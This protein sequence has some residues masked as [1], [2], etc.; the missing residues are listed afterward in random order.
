[1]RYSCRFRRNNVQYEVDIFPLT[2]PLHQKDHSKGLSSTTA[3]RKV[4]ARV[5]VFATRSH[6]KLTNI[7]TWHWRLDHVGY[8][9]IKCMGHEQVVK[10]IDV[11]TY[12]KGQGSCK[13]CIMG[14]HTRRPFNDNLSQETEVLERVYINLW[15]PAR[16]RS[17]GG[18]RYMMQAVDRK[19]THAEG[20][21]LA[22]KSAKTT[23][24]AFKSYHVMAERQTGKKLKCI[25]TDGGGEFCNDLWDSYCKEF[26]IIH[27]TTSSYLSQSNGVVDS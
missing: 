16:T 5:L 27:E 22:E 10:G 21:Y 19:S 8:S 4:H 15:G 18:K 2:G 9:V 6:N 3:T 23:L 26:R 17:N 24:E 13:D 14:K 20:Y 25:R 7:N 1:M 12:E 11:T